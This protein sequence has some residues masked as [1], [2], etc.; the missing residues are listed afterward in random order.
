MQELFDIISRE[1]P[2]EINEIRL[3][4][5][6]SIAYKIGNKTFRLQRICTQSMLTEILRKVTLDSV[7]AVAEY[8]PCGYISYNG[9]IRIGLAGEYS[10]ENGKPKSI[11]NISGLVI[12]LPKEITNCSKCVGERNFDKNILIVSMPYAGKTTFLRDLARRMSQQRQV[13]VIDER[14]E[15]SGDRT[16]DV[17]DSLVLS[18]IAKSELFEGVIR[19]LSPETVITDELFG[20]KEYQIVTDMMS[21]GVKV[22]ASVHGDSLEYLPE[23]LKKFDVKILLK[24]YPEVGSVA[25]VK[26]G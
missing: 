23:A 6:K 4:V 22:V 24:S 17:G 21:K 19:S 5:D 7:Y 25:E 18:G 2:K 15:L 16:L 11:K 12:R 8:L 1:L 3:V 9:G 10:L 13:V 14:K 26:Y 20:A